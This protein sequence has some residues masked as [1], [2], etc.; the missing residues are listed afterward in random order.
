[1]GDILLNDVIPKKKVD[2]VELKKHLSSSLYLPKNA[3]TKQKF[4][5]IQL[6][7]IELKII[8]WLIRKLMKEKQGKNFIALFSY[9]K[10]DVKL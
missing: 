8:E 1:M 7:I 9:K 4:I 2:I 5:I 6:S 10:I 3:E